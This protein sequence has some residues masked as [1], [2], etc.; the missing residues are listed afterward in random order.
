MKYST[1]LKYTHAALVFI[2]YGLPSLPSLAN[3]NVPVPDHHEWN[4]LLKTYVITLPSGKSTQVDY[5]GLAHDAATLNRYLQ[6]LSAV[7]MK[8]FAAWNKADQLAFLINAYNAWTVK[9]ILDNY[10]SIKSIKDLG[11]LFQ[12]PWK[13]EFIPL[14]GKN[15]SLDDIEHGLIRGSNRYQEPR[16]HFAANCASI[17]CPAL[18]EEAYLGSK[19]EAQLEQ[20]AQRF[21]GDKTRNFLEGKRLKVSSIFKWYRE[22]FEK[23]WRDANTLPDFL[24]LYAEPLGLQATDILQLRQGKITIDYQDYDWQL[25]R[26]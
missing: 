12:S 17:G 16:I 24:A 22:D 13:K 15:R 20:Q 26:K 1:R 25:N 4:A 6:T 9:L 19:L 5:I 10:A 11:S 18:R 3:E 14:L 7:D 21:L 2:I 8:R 23:G